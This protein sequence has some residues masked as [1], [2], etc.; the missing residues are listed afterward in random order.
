M[1]DPDKFYSYDEL[2]E[3]R[4]LGSRQHVRRLIK[5]GIVPAPYRLGGNGGRLSWHGGDRSTRQLHDNRAMGVYAHRSKRAER[6]E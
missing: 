4:I 5:A 2:H 3:R 6:S 1:L